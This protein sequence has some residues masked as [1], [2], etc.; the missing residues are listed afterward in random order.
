MLEPGNGYLLD[1]DSPGTL[2]YPEFN[3]L[4]RSLESKREIILSENFEI[5]CKEYSIKV[6]EIQREGKQS[7]N[8][9]D[10]IQGTKIKKGIDLNH[11]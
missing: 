4:T 11:E 5:G 3:S 7:Q 9:K 10:F 1:M 2:F 8:I 6:L